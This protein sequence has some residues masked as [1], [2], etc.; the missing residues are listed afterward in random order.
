MV[1]LQAEIDSIR[2]YFKIIRI[3]YDNRFELGDQYRGEAF[4]LGSPSADH[5][6][7]SG[8]CS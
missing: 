5:P 1:T 8:E 3:R 4:G 7:C 6:A 2:N